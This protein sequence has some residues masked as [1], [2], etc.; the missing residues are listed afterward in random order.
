MTTETTVT[1]TWDLTMRTPLGKIGAQVT[2]VDA[3][4]TLSGEAVGTS[5]TVPLEN[6]QVRPDPA[7]QR[8]TWRQSITR[9]MRLNLDFDVVVSGD[10]VEGS[11]RAGRLPASTVT[12]HRTGASDGDDGGT[13]DRPESR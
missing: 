6:I 9:P 2:I 10:V 12:G 7:G 11:S 3:G 13:G 8:V 1:G 5:E 4:G